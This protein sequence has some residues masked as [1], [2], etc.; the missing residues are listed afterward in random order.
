[1]HRLY[2]P[3]RLIVLRIILIARVVKLCHVKLER[4][5]IKNKKTKKQKQQDGVHK[6]K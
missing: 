3:I 5:F 4:Q 1:M 6:W 2:I